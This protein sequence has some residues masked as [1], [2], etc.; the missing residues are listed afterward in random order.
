MGAGCPARRDAIGEANE[1]VLRR[2]AS[3]RGVVADRTAAWRARPYGHEYVPPF[4]PSEREFLDSMLESELHDLFQD[5]S[6]AAASGRPAGG[7][8]EGDKKTARDP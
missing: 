5:V 4:T 2:E 1:D 8:E 3:A 6:G 7:A